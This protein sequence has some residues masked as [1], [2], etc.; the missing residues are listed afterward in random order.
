MDRVS[1]VNSGSEKHAEVPVET[2]MLQWLW[3]A[4]LVLVLDQIT[5]LWVSGIFELHERLEIL[6]FFNLTLAHN[7]GAAFSFLASAGGWQRWF[8]TVIAVVVS[9]VLIN[10]LR[11]LPKTDRWMAISLGLILGG[12]L[13]NLLDR[14]MYGYV[15]DFLDFHWQG[16]HFPAFNVADSGI[17][18]GAIMMAIDVFRSPS[19]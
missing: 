6:P 18:V 16:T 7:Y 9:G 14:A 13:G 10:W 12:A 8:F 4:G 11:T 15:V 5:K 2:G 17:T 1:D 19:K 3:L